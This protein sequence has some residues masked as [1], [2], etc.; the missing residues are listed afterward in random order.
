MGLLLRSMSLFLLYMS[1]CVLRSDQGTNL[2]RN[3]KVT[4]CDR[5]GGASKLYF[6]SDLFYVCFHSINNVRD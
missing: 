3:L 5:D 4:S 1:L 6:C 2:G